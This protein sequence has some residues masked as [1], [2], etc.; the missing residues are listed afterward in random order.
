MPASPGRTISS[1]SPMLTERLRSRSRLTE[2]IASFIFVRVPTARSVVAALDAAALAPLPAAACE[3]P[4]RSPKIRP[5]GRSVAAR[6]RRECDVRQQGTGD[7]ACT[8][9]FDLA[10]VSGRP[11]DLQLHLSGT[12]SPPQNAAPTLAVLLNDQLVTSAALPAGAD[13]FDQRITLP[14]AQLRGDNEVTV[15]VTPAAGSQETYFWQLDPSSALLAASRRKL[16]RLLASSTPQVVLPM[17]MP[18]RSGSRA[19]MTCASPSRP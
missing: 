17:R 19:R 18:I 11:A 6:S 14:A 8:F 13:H 15:L 2:R 7:T 9:H 10:K 12:I 3:P 5:A 1:S 16:P 4:P